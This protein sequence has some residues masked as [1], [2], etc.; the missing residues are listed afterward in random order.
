MTPVHREALV[1]AVR[2]Y[3]GECFARHTAV[4]VKE[5]AAILGLSRQHVSK[6]FKRVVGVPPTELLLDIQIAEA[7]RLLSATSKTIEEVASAAGFG[8]K[9]TLYRIFIQ[10]VGMSPEEFRNQATKCH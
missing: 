1:E 5:L 3:A 8:T 9:R 10:K 6:T 2:A 4:R 7:R